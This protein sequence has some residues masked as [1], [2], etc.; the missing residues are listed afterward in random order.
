MASDADADYAL[1]EVELGKPETSKAIENVG[2]TAG[3]PELDLEDFTQDVRGA[4][5]LDEQFQQLQRCHRP[6]LR[7]SGGRELDG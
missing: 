1:F 2:R 5:G 7:R 6:L 3:I 4:V